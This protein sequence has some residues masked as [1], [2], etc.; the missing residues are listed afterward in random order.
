[1]GYPGLGR[2]VRRKWPLETGRTLDVIII[3]PSLPDSS[4]LTNSFRIPKY[5]Q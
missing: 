4:N 5:C 3:E 2:L 1:M